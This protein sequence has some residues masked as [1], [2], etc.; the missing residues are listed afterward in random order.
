MGP[1]MEAP[2]ASVSRASKQADWR[3]P[4]RSIQTLMAVVGG[5]ALKSSSHR[6][7]LED[8]RRNEMVPSSFGS[9]HLEVTSFVCGGGASAAEMDEGGK[10]LPL[11]LVSR[12]VPRPGEDGSYVPVQIY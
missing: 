7:D 12:Y 10:I 9:V 11:P 1:R 6:I 3:V 8:V 2:K 4:T 5:K